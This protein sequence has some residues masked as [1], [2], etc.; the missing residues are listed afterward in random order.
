MINKIKAVWKVLQIGKSLADPQKWKRKQIQLTT[1]GG[2]FIGIAQLSKMFNY[3]I[4]L[5]EDTATAIAAAIIGV[6][7]WYFTLATST[8]VGVV[9]KPTEAPL[10]ELAKADTINAPVEIVDHSFTK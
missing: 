1:L 10:P 2:F 8:K 7:N 6:V 3:D 5:D 9:S 4:Y